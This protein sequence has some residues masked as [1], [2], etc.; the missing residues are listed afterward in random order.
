MTNTTTLQLAERPCKMGNAINVRSQ[1]HGD[2]DVPA[3]EIPIV[4]FLLEEAEL[5]ALL[6]KGAYK[7]L[8]REPK[9]G[10]AVEP[11]FE[12]V[13][14][15]AIDEKFVGSVSLDLETIDLEL[16]S[17]NVTLA[18]VKLTP[19]VGG[20]TAMSLNVQCT[21]STDEIAQLAGSMNRA[22]RA[23]INFGGRKQPKGK[24]QKELPMGPHA[25]K[26]GNDLDA[27]AAGEGGAGEVTH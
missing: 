11:R 12:H 5:D 13:T 15:L 26:G 27:V 4:N 25:Q 17:E 14:E 24:K 10:K 6:G 22:I 19:Q 23:S 8:Y 3:C 18:S 9:N 21:P 16:T 7:A 2:E 1:K 20:L